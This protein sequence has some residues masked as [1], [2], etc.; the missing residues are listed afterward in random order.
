[1]L[2]KLRFTIE[3]TCPRLAHPAASVTGM[4]GS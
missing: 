1:M 3:S 2:V 4:E